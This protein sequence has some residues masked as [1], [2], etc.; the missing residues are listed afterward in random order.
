MENYQLARDRERRNVKMLRKYGIA[1]LISYTLTVANDVN[2]GEPMS[3]KE[4]MSSDD[5]MKWYAAM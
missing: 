4:A 1:D 3:F 2:G 5:K